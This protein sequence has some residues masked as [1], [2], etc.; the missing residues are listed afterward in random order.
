VT[1]R[2]HAFV[3][4]PFGVKPGPRGG[5]GKP[6]DPNLETIDFNRIYQGDAHRYAGTVSAGR[7][8]TIC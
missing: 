7:R 5:G 6:L 8:A 4:M 2:P 1:A 3:G